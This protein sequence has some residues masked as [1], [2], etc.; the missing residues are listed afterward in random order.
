M[1][2]DEKTGNDITK[3]DRLM[4]FFK[5]KG[6]N[7]GNTEDES[8]IGY[9]MRYMPHILLNRYAVNASTY[10]CLEREIASVTSITF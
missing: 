3:N 10:L 4:N 5:Y 6:S 8:K 9:Q 7:P 1:W 2:P